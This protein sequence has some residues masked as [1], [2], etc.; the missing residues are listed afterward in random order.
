MLAGRP[1]LDNLKMVADVIVSPGNSFATIRDNYHNYYLASICVTFAALASVVLF[2]ALFSREPY[3]L[4]LNI[5][6]GFVGIVI[7]A[8]VFHCVSRLFG[9]SKN[10][11][12]AFTVYFYANSVIFGMLAIVGIDM[13]MRFALLGFSMSFDSLL[14][15]TIFAVWWAIVSV[16]ALKAVNGFGTGKALGAWLLGLIVLAV[17]SSGAIITGV[18]TQ[19][20]DDIGALLGLML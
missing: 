1:S 13:L 16:K 7:Q 5:A 12:Q 18:T 14:L 4:W 2:V 17:A 8:A 11:M 19:F 10:A 3:Q 15:T 6:V 20:E 9:G